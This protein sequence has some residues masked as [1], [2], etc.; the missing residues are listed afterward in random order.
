MQLTFWPSDDPEFLRL[1]ARTS[2]PS[3]AG[4]KNHQLSTVAGEA[5]QERDA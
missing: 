5:L 4:R 1:F 3:T 2:W